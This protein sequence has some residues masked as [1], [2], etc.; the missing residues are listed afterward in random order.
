[1]SLLNWDAGSLIPG[2]EDALAMENAVECKLGWRRKSIRVMVFAVTT[3]VLMILSVTMNA[4][5]QINEYVNLADLPYSQYYGGPDTVQL[6]VYNISSNVTLQ[7]TF[8]KTGY[9]ATSLLVD[10][11]FY[12]DIE[13]GTTIFSIPA[14]RDVTLAF[15]AQGLSLLLERV[16][17]HGQ[18][19]NSLDDFTAAGYTYWDEYQR[20]EGFSWKG[21]RS[22]IPLPPE[23]G[24]AA[25]YP[26]RSKAGYSIPH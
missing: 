9:Y 26:R 7:A 25:R 24:H 21:W 17:V 16:P 18:L 8:Q 14:Q 20:Y 12:G 5:G 13:T 1:M 4:R 23:N 19:N 2:S 22:V 15:F 6:S 3:T 10:Y 11:E